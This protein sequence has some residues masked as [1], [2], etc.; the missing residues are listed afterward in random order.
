MLTG[1]EIYLSALDPTQVSE[2]YVSWFNDPATFRFL[3]SKF[4][5]TAT[6]VRD[7]VASVKAPNFVS[8]IMRTSDD[9]H[10][11]NIAMYNFHPIHRRMELGIVIGDA[12]CRGR[13]VGREACRLA[14]THVFEHLNLHKVTAGAVADN[15]SMARVFLSLGFT[16]EGTLREHYF[17]GDRYRD[18][19]VFGLTRDGFRPDRPAATRDQA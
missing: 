15:V 13:G 4:P 2:A 14:I 9:R 12:S 8:R 19:H 6:S 3:G 7:Y 10:I 16:I 11:G 17:L 1:T 5:Q 18:Y